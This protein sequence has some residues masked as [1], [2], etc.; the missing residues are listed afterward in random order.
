MNHLS[1]ATAELL[2]E[3]HHTAAATDRPTSLSVWV[4][5]LASA[6]AVGV[7]VDWHSYCSRHVHCC[8]RRRWP[9]TW[10]VLCFG[11]AASDCEKPLD[12]FNQRQVKLICLIPQC[13]YVLLVSFIVR[14][15]CLV[16]TLTILLSRWCMCMTRLVY[17]YSKRMWFEDLFARSRYIRLDSLLQG[18]DT[19]VSHTQLYSPKHGRY[20]I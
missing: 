2:V 14:V 18:T 17:L 10:Q 16:V 7:V 20:K 5:R 3:T 12:A 9:W 8:R 4:V 19:N 6:F 11:T 13:C 15:V 1:L